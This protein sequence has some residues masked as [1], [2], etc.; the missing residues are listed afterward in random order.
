MVKKGS[1]LGS[2]NT[3]PRFAPRHRARSFSDSVSTLTPSMRISPRVGD[4][5]PERQWN[6]VVL[7]LPEGPVTPQASPSA[8]WKLGR[9]RPRTFFLLL[10]GIH[11]TDRLPATCSFSC[12]TCK[13][14]G[15]ATACT[16]SIPP[17]LHYWSMESAV[18]R[19]W[20]TNPVSG[21]VSLPTSR[22]PVTEMGVS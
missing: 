4:S 15:C 20:L 21:S 3:Y 22:V 19:S 14:G 7:P 17:D 11:T 13:K 8:S 2:W 1:S 9:T 5:K 10:P 6:R 18:M 12:L 16:V